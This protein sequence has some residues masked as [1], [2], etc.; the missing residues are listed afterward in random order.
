MALTIFHVISLTFPRIHYEYRKY[1]G[2]LSVPHTIVIELYNV[3]IPLKYRFSIK[4]KCQS[5]K[6]H[7]PY[8]HA[9]WIVHK[10]QFHIYRKYWHRGLIISNTYGNLHLLKWKRGVFVATKYRSM[11]SMVKNSN[12]ISLANLLHCL[13]VVELVQ[14]HASNILDMVSFM[15]GTI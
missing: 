6:A 4:K 12:T 1:N 14:S 13:F 2:I 8:E 15:R 7:R 3:L 9:E 10:S 5:H 11:K